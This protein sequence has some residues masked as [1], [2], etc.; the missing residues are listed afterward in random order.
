M[1]LKGRHV[2]NVRLPRNTLERSFFHTLLV[3]CFGRATSNQAIVGFP[4]EDASGD[5][6]A[7]GE[8]ASHY[9]QVADALHDGEAGISYSEEEMLGKCTNEFVSSFE[10]SW[11]Q[12]LQRCI[13]TRTNSQ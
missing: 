11:I 9:D 6:E 3:A 5:G 10:V 12:I 2:D 8:S 7:L 13:E 4:G 1:Y